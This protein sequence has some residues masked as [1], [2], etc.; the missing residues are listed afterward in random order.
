[1]FKIYFMTIRIFIIS[2]RNIIMYHVLWI[3]NDFYPYTHNTHNT[4]L[5]CCGCCGCRVFFYF[6]NSTV[7]RLIAHTVTAIVT[8][9]FNVFRV[10]NARVA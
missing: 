8:T 10:R 7:L 1:M 9:F 3:A 4:G 6:T 5:Q 2:I